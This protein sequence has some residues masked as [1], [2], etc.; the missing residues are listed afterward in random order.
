MH[1]CCYDSS[2]TLLIALLSRFIGYGYC[3]YDSFKYKKKKNH[4]VSN[5]H[6]WCHSFSNWFYTTHDLLEDGNELITWCKVEASFIGGFIKW[7]FV[8]SLRRCFLHKNK[9]KKPLNHSI[10]FCLR[11]RSVTNLD[12]RPVLELL[13]ER[14]SL[15]V[16]FV[17]LNRLQDFALL[18]GWLIVFLWYHMLQDIE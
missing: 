8:E 15:C 17:S 7:S 3:C 10:W 4:H 6:S 14:M 12:K 11:K 1:F 2:Q 16:D 9:T 5:R 13:F 18:F